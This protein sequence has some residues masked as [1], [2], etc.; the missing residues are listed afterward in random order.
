MAA[1]VAALVTPAAAGSSPPASQQKAQAQATTGTTIDLQHDRVLIVALGRDESTACQPSSKELGLNAKISLLQ[2]FG[3]PLTGINVADWTG[4]SARL[5]V[6]GNRYASWPDLESLVGGGGAVTSEGVNHQALLGMSKSDQWQDVCGVE[7]AYADHGLQ[8]TGMYAYSGGPY[9]A[10]FQNH[11]VEYCSALG[12]R[13]SERLNTMSQLAAPW[14]L[15]VHS[16]NGGCNAARTTCFGVRPPQKYQ[17]VGH[18]LNTTV[19]AAG[20]VAVLQIYHLVSGQTVNWNCTGA[21]SQHATYRTEYYCANDLR[22]FL[23]ALPAGVKF[24]TIDDLAA[25]VGRAPGQLPGLTLQ[26]YLNGPSHP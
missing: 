23:S 17:T 12:R 22:A 11:L 3:A 8:A 13:Y 1:A 7:Q 20:Q 25:A 4:E 21:R 15:Y 18:L 26:Q 9:D 16:L 24:A 14:T 19:P 10:W 5:C 2:S 6:R